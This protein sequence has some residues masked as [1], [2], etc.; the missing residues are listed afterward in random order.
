[1]QFLNSHM[2]N[3]V[4]PI[5]YV[6]WSDKWSCGLQFILIKQNTLKYIPLYNISKN[7][8]N[9]P[10][11]IFT[12]NNTFLKGLDC[13]HLS[14]KTSKKK[15]HNFLIQ[16]QMC[17]KIL[18]VLYNINTKLLIYKDRKLHILLYLIKTNQ[19]D[20][21]YFFNAKNLKAGNVK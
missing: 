6:H 13:K 14:L 20:C 4:Q 19:T 2:I 7:H 9:P 5:K 3:L 16:G 15:K 12:F 1:M 21:F 11:L 18:L 17:V 10:L 8:F